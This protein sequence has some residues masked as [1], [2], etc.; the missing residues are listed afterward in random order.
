MGSTPHL[1]CPTGQRVELRLKCGTIIT[2]K[3]REN[4]G[5]FVELLDGRKIAA[6]RI[7]TFRMLRGE[8]HVRK[9]NP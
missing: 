5:K 6:G 3:F 8:P 2:G 9:P 4:R 1:H 7:R